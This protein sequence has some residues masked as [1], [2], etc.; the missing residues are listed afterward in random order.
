M[1][2]AL[3]PP[4]VGSAAPALQRPTPIQTGLAASRRDEAAAADMA[5][6][7]A[8]VFEQFVSG[9]YSGSV[10]AKLTSQFASSG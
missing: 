2:A 6:D 5:G 10:Q 4:I 9:R 3:P 7:Q 8:L 1:V